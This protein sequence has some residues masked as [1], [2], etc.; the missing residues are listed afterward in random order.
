MTDHPPVTASGDAL[1]VATPG[2]GRGLDAQ[3]L[4]ELDEHGYLVVRA[5]VPDDWIGPL[6][7]AFD[8]GVLPSDQWPVPRGR[9]WQHAL[10]DTD[11]YVQRVC[12]LPVLLDAA[13]HVLNA[14]FFLSQVEGRAPC[15][16]N[17]AQPLHR[18][19]AGSPR[20]LMAAMIWLDPYAQHNGAT[21]I[22]PASHRGEEG[23][24]GEA[25]AE[26][27]VLTGAAGDILIFDPDTLHGATTNHSGAPR[28][29]L[30]L[31]YAAAALQAEHRETERLRGVRMDTSEIFE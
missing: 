10:L 5:G 1:P 31:L 27:T 2:A 8:A 20:Q 19:G 12:R 29:S 14:P 4:R 24:G 11:P 25:A 7:A 26:P 3:A 15:R 17:M 21:Q 13:R 30:L 9:D 23:E 18:D 16:G 22:V 6:R 28:R